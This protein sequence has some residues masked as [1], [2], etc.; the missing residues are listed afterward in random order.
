[1][2]SEDG[3]YSVEAGPKE[4]LCPNCQAKLAEEAVV[5]A[6]CGFDLA[7]GQ[8]VDRVYE[9]VERHWESSM[10]L[11]RRVTVFIVGQAVVLPL[12]LLAA[13]FQG[14]PFVFIVPWLTFSGLL[15]F[16][17]GTYD[18]IDLKRNKRGQV[19]LAK[20]WRVC[21]I[22]RPTLK[23]NPFEYEGIKIMRR[24]DLN[25]MDLAMLV[26]LGIMGIFPAILWWLWARNHVT[27]N[28]AL[29]QHHGYPEMMLYHGGSEAQMEEI[30]EILQDATGMPCERI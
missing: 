5:C 15:A 12:A 25:I 14:A 2:E 17:L 6:R 29:T 9:K 30:A 3:P 23:I 11:R 7:T 8:K 1:M 21:F 20:T 16:M 28:V 22:E 10:S 27:Y 18:R 4:N 13:Y 26:A 19:Q 24:H